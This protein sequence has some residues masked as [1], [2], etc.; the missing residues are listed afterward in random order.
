MQSSGDTATIHV[1]EVKGKNVAG[2]NAI[3][4]VGRWVCHPSTHEKPQ[5]SN[6]TGMTL[7]RDAFRPQNNNILSG[8][9]AASGQESARDRRPT[10]NMAPSCNDR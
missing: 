9:S 7:A 1:E 2:S 3:C 5:T 4:Q 8:D 6:L 10:F